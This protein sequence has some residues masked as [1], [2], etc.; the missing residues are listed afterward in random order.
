VLPD[1][2]FYYCTREG[3]LS[4][5]SV[6]DKKLTVKPMN[7]KSDF[8]ISS[9]LGLMEG[10]PVLTLERGVKA[11]VIARGG[12]YF[13]P[14]CEHP[15]FAALA[16]AVAVFIGREEEALFTPWAWKALVVRKGEK[17]SCAVMDAT[18]DWFFVGGPRGLRAWHQNRF[19]HPIRLEALKDGVQGL[20]IDGRQR[21]LYTLEKNAVRRWTLSD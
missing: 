14:G 5:G 7:L 17:N 3:A 19:H 6:V 4:L 13:M 12:V 15:L 16:G 10:Q 2:D 18:S 1:L 21:A 11:G 8:R 9:I 20:S